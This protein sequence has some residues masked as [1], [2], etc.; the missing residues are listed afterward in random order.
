MGRAP[1]T[2]LP[3]LRAGL[4]VQRDAGD[5]CHIAKS[6]TT[7]TVAPPATN[8]VDGTTPQ[9]IQDSFTS[10]MTTVGGHVEV[11]AAYDACTNASD[12][13]TRATVDVTMTK[14]AFT[15]G[16]GRAQASQADAAI[17]DRYFSLINAHED[18]HI[19]RNKKAFKN[20]HKKLLNKKSD[21][22]VAAYDGVQCA[23]GQADEALDNAEGCVRFTTNFA[24]AELVP[25]TTCGF[26]PPDYTGGICP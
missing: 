20:A 15:W 4:T 19:A 18:R 13:V 12:T 24:G 16:T 11:D 21:K 17:I 10:A 7:I 25:V 5:D 3:S 1:A 23:A 9:E 8:A 14:H 26:D 6:K 2:V 22:A